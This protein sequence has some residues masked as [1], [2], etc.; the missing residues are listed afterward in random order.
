MYDAIQE[1]RKLWDSMQIQRD[2]E[3]I[4]RRQVPLNIFELNS[5]DDQTRSCS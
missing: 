2:D 4:L 3:E 5:Q 1:R